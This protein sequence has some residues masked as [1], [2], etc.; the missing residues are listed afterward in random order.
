MT[1]TYQSWHRMQLF[2]LH[3]YHTSSAHFNRG[4]PPPSLSIQHEGC[5]SRGGRSPVN[6]S[7]DEG[8]AWLNL[9]AWPPCVMDNYI[10]RGWNKLSTRNVASWRRPCAKNIHIYSQPDSR[11]KWTPN[12]K[13]LC[14]MTLVTTVSDKHRRPM[15]AYAVKKYYVKK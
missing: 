2:P 12:H 7:S 6:R 4:N 14:A 8:E 9:N 15:N 13:G 10:K 3:D 5:A 1:F 11:G